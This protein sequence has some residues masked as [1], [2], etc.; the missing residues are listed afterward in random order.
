MKH[1]DHPPNVR[2]AS[3]AAS[4][5]RLHLNKGLSPGTSDAQTSHNLPLSLHKMSASAVTQTR[6][7]PD[8]PVNDAA[9]IDS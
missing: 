8:E 3:Q 2:A 9:T 1:R 7:A 4:G 5:R 6:E